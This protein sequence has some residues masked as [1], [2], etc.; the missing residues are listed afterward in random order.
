VA[1]ALSIV[2]GEVRELVRRRSLDPV[3]EPDATRGLV[4]DVIADYLDRALISALP[5]LGDPVAASRSVFDQVAGF[6]A[7][8]PY[9]DDPTVEEIWVNEPGRIF[10]AR[11][12]RSEL[13]TVILTADQVSDLVERM[14]RLSGRRLDLS[15]P[16][17]D[18]QLPD[19]SR[20]HV[21]IPAITRA[22]MAVNTAI[23][24]STRAKRGMLRLVRGALTLLIGVGVQ[25]RVGRDRARQAFHRLRF[26]GRMTGCCIGARFEAW[27]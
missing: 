24:L 2:E 27:Q 6:G 15:T 26:S 18:A 17:V 12:G 4:D 3:L 13:T 23:Q 1:T 10:V 19:G 8:Q 14:L 16:F 22:H 25:E 7:L 21:V 20:L 11:H 9:L 5:P